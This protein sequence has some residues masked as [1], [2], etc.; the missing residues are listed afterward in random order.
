[1]ECFF[2]IDYYFE[3]FKNKHKILPNSYMLRVIMLNASP[4]DFSRAALI[5][6]NVNILNETNI[7]I[8]EFRGD[9]LFEV[10]FI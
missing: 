1:M 5:M 2:L 6:E 10:T 4:Q 3:E 7:N 9:T 8:N